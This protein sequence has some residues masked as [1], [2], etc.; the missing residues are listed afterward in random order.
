M[1]PRPPLTTEL[2]KRLGL[3]LAPPA[4]Y[5]WPV[6]LLLVALGIG[7]LWLAGYRPLAGVIMLVGLGVLPAIRWMERREFLDCER[8][9][10]QGQEG[11]AIVQEVE[12]AGAQRNDHLVR[13][14][15]FAQGQRIPAVVSGSPLARKGLSPGDGVNV[16]YDPADPRHCLLIGRV[17][18]EVLDAEF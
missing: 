15:I 9:Y 7:P 11:F 4:H 6:A 5:P 3:P 10:E 13:L 16:I 1:S 14:E 17:R 8:L 12:P 2:R 18:Q